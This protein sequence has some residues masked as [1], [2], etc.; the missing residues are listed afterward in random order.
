MDIKHFINCSKVD[1]LDTHLRKN[2]KNIPYAAILDEWAY[3]QLIDEMGGFDP[4]FKY[5]MRDEI[6]SNKYIKLHGILLVPYPSIYMSGTY[7]VTKELFDRITKPYDT[8]LHYFGR[9]E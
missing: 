7:F 4:E 8:V 2:S 3:D 6:R 5:K 9:E 1:V